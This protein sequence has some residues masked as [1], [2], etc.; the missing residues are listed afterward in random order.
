MWN[1]QIT[2]AK[3]N[4]VVRFLI[5][6]LSF[7]GYFSSGAA[8]ERNGLGTAIELLELCGDHGVRSLSRLRWPCSK[9]KRQHR[10]AQNLSWRVSTFQKTQTIPATCAEVFSCMFFHTSTRRGVTSSSYAMASM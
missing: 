6:T 10:V 3:V 8:L 5:M 2:R 1:A 4:H 7:I 9:T